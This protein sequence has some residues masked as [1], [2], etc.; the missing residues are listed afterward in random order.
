M[1]GVHG[2]STTQL[3]HF[4]GIMRWAYCGNPLLHQSFSHTPEYSTMYIAKS[5]A[6]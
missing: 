2:I 5:K 1:V 4:A 6:I 3:G